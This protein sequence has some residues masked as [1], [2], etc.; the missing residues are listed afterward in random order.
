[1]TEYHCHC[2]PDLGYKCP[3]HKS[4]AMINNPL[5]EALREQIAWT[6]KNCGN[7]PYVP[8]KMA[9]AKAILAALASSAPVTGEREQIVG[10]LGIASAP[11]D[12]PVCVKAGSMTFLARLIGNEAMT[13]EGQPCDQWHAEIEGEHPPCWSGGACWT[14]NENEDLS[15]QPTHW[16]LPKPGR[17]GS[18]GE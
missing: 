18:A 5:V 13:T 3:L 9:D 10:W 4:P 2:R 11:Y 14:S 7:A 15:L 17:D 6:E 16:C 1:M 12:V 8:V